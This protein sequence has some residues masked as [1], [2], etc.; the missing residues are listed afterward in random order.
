MESERS[1]WQIPERHESAFW[2]EIKADGF[3]DRTVQ[4]A[5]YYELTPNQ[6]LS[7]CLDLGYEVLQQNAEDLIYLRNKTG[8]DEELK[9]MDPKFAYDKD[10]T[11]KTQKGKI[12]P[13]IFLAPDRDLAMNAA[14]SFGIDLEELAAR[15]IQ[16]GL[17]SMEQMQEGSRL[18]QKSQGQTF[19]MTFVDIS[20]KQ[21][22]KECMQQLYQP[23]LL[24]M[25]QPNTEPSMEEE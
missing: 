25:P 15:M 10:L 6:V 18:Y 17:Y 22:I 20:P 8:N 7:L 3:W 2:Q 14:N 12:L 19:R 5:V 9:L 21:K 16:M 13:V 1:E 23:K 4:A 11:L 24:E